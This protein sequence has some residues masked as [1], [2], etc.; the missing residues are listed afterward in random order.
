MAY[1]GKMATLKRS[2]LVSVALVSLLSLSLSFYYFIYRPQQLSFY[3]KGCFRILEEVVEN[4]KVSLNGYKKAPDPYINDSAF[5]KNEGSSYITIG[6]PRKESINS[7]RDT[8][9]LDTLIRNET[10]SNLTRP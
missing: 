8:A 7:T 3:N 5:I 10:D 9:F 2:V 6:S 4:F 1:A